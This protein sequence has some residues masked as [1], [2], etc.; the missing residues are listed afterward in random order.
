MTAFLSIIGILIL[1]G[2]VQFVQYL[3]KKQSACKHLKQNNNSNRFRI[4]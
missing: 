3:Q 2:G 1:A 4:L